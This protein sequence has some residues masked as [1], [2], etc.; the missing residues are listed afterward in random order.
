MK[1]QK[2]K[3]QSQKFFS[4]LPNFNEPSASGG[5][6]RTPD[7]PDSTEIEHPIQRTELEILWP[8]EDVLPNFDP[9]TPLLSPLKRTQKSMHA[10]LNTEDMH[11][12]LPSICFL[13]D[14]QN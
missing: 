8:A 2:R 5:C 10:A 6:I 14:A 11:A 12:Y 4:V 7:F 9:T 3:S 13:S 1:I